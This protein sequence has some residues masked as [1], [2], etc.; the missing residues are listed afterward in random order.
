MRFAPR[1]VKHCSFLISDCAVR[2]KNDSVWRKIDSGHRRFI[3]EDSLSESWLSCNAPRAPTDF[4]GI[5]A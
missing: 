2:S 3:A 1:N 5:Y 4:G